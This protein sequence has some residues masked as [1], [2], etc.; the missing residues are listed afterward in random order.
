M[1]LTFIFLRK[2]YNGEV[3]VSIGGYIVKSERTRFFTFSA[4]YMHA[5]FGFAFKEMDE[6]ISIARLR[7]PFQ[8]H[9]W[10]IIGTFLIISSAII[11]VTKKLN[12]KYRHFLIGGQ[13]NR[14]PIFNML[15]SLL[16][17]PITNPRMTQSRH[18]STFARTLTIL[19]IFLWLVIRNS[20]QGALYTY[21]Q[22]NRLS[23]PYDTIDK[24]NKSDCK[25]MVTVQSLGMLEKMFRKD[26]Y[27]FFEI[28]N[29][30]TNVTDFIIIAESSMLEPN[31]YQI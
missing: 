1:T 28:Y 4:P 11:L 13:M 24:I 20:Y 30:I 15:T 19:W 10:A 16:G 7:A 23:S 12:K 25:I 22:S 2:V 27:K 6:Y 9:L 18:F 14:T 21:L 17:L 3:N 5:S 31:F 29:F 8:L 26:R